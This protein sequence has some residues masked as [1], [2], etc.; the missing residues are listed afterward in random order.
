MRTGSVLGAALLVAGTTIGAGMLA[1]PTV[2]GPAGFWPSAGVLAVYWL[3]SY[4]CGQMFIAVTLAFEEPVN[5][6]S[7]VKATLGRGGEILCW[8]LYLGLL[9]S[10][11]AAYLS[12]GHAIVKSLTGIEPTVLL[13]VFGAVIAMGAFAVDW[14]NRVFMVGLVVA[15][16]MLIGAMAPKLDLSLLSRTNGSMVWLA[17]PTVV[18]SFGYQ[19][20]IPTLSQY[21]H[22]DRK[23]IHRAV[24]WGSLS[25]LIVY[26]IFQFIMLGSVTPEQVAFAQK[27]GEPIL[28]STIAVAFS[29]FAIITS[30]LGVSLSLRDFLGDAF[31]MK[32]R[33]I[34]VVLTFLPPLLFAILI[35]RAFLIA[36]D[37]AGIIVCLLLGLMP[38]ALVLRKKL[39][40]WRAKAA[41]VV[42]GYTATIIADWVQRL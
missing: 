1:L 39:P 3:L 31:R 28:P 42:I 27:A 16:V 21:L 33:A 38:V 26:L 15:Y 37:W 32:N 7:M 36:L 2:L 18:T 5:L 13:V 22:R 40:G 8:V 34:P 30:L 41:V 14:V 29:F 10:L 11:T 17:L 24:L 25:G 6:H 35:P 19:I 4:F 20:I 23:K 9:Y 12:G